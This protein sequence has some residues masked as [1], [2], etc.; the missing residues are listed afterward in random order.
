M[1]VPMRE[2]ERPVTSIA[3]PETAV[4]PVPVIVGAF[5]ASSVAPI[6]I[7]ASIFDV[8]RSYLNESRSFSMRRESS[9]ASGSRMIMVPFEPQLGQGTLPVG[10]SALQAGHWS[11]TTLHAGKP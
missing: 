6:G 11:T 3:G 10:L 4:G 7:T 1:K 9:T 2:F 5:S 8:A